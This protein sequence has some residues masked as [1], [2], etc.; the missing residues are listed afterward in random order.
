MLC[1]RVC[2]A[3]GQRQTDGLRNGFDGTYGNS[4]APGTSFEPGSRSAIGERQSRWIAVDCRRLSHRN[5]RAWT[6]IRRARLQS[7]IVKAELGWTEAKRPSAAAT[8]ICVAAR[9]KINSLAAAVR[10]KNVVLTEID[11]A[12]SGHDILNAVSTHDGR[13]IFHDPLG[14]IADQR[15]PVVGRDC[16]LIIGDGIWRSSLII[17]LEECLG[18]PEEDKHPVGQYEILTLI[19]LPGRENGKVK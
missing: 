15:F 5:Q 16:H 11:R 4:G 3:V 10:Y 6:V 12:V 7:H 8:R 14:T 18:G 19:T 13:W 1:L 2:G 17:P 9:P